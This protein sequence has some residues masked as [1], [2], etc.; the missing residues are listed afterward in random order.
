MD[1][2][3]ARR[4]KDPSQATAALNDLDWAGNPG[5]ATSLRNSLAN[6]PATEICIA[7]NVSLFAAN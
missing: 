4:L 1:P 2:E 7:G 5:L 6:S 3:I